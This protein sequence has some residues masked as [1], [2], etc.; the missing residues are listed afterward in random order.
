[1]VQAV[2]QNDPKLASALAEGIRAT[3]NADRVLGHDAVPAA[4]P[5][6]V[7]PP[8]Q[9]QRILAQAAGRMLADAGG[10]RIA[11]LD[12][13][14]WDTHAGQGA[15]KGRLAGALDG[16]SAG[17]LSLRAALGPAWQDTVVPMVTEFG[18]TAHANGTGGTD[19]GTASAMLLAGGAIA[20]GTVRGSWPGLADGKLYQSRDLMPTTDMRAVLKGVLRDHLGVPAARLDSAIFPN[21]SDAKPMAGVTVWA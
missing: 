19:H 4:T 16:L 8:H 2:Y 15:A 9:D 3:R 10:P 12:V 11:V 20:G 5:G 7:Q 14:G 1:M 21:S 18:R 17:L 6:V 13:P